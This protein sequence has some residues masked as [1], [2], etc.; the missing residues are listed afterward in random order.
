MQKLRLFVVLEQLGPVRSFQWDPQQPRLAICS[1]GS[2]VYLWSPAG[3]VSVQVPG[4]GDFQV[5]SL[6]WPVTGDSLALLSKDHFCLCFLETEDGA[7]AL[8]QLDDHT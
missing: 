6:C 3:C 8:G 1:G 5:L 4:E 7:D 2:K